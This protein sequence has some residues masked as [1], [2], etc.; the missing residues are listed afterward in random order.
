M[1]IDELLKCLLLLQLLKSHKLDPQ[2]L[3]R[4]YLFNWLQY[5]ICTCVFENALSVCRNLILSGLDGIPVEGSMPYL[6]KGWIRNLYWWRQWLSLSTLS[7]SSPSPL[8]LSSLFLSHSWVLISEKISIT[9][10][11]G[12]QQVYNLSLLY[13][14]ELC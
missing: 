9:E 14:Y 6:F 10:L 11:P 4:F 3:I 5:S 8:S 2:S 13:E 7:T 1:K 12:R